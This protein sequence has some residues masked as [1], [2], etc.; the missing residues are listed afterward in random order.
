MRGVS[1]K[2]WVVLSDHIK[3]DEDLVARHGSF[4]AQL[5]VN[6]GY[7]REGDRLFD[8]K[9]K[10]LLPYRLLPNVEE[11]V[12]RIEWAVKRE[13]RIIIFGDY[14]VD[15]ITGTAILYDVLKEAGARVIPVLPTRETG[16]GLSKDLMALFS[17]Y[18]D[19][20]ITVDN[21]TSSVEEIEGFPLEV[22]VIDHHNV[23]ERVPRGC[24]IVNPRVSPETPPPMRELSSS[25]VCF[26]IAAV[27]SKRLG[28]E[29]DV[30]E[31][32]DLV[33]LGTVGD[34]MPMNYI[35]RILVHKGIKVLEGVARGVINKP[36]VRSLLKVSGIGDKVSAKDLAYSL[37]PRINAPGRIGD[38]K[39]SLKLLL[40]RDPK[41]AEVLARKVD[42][43]N[44]KRRAITEMVFRSAYRKA[45]RQEGM[46][47]LALWDRDWHVGVLGIVAGRIAEALGK[48]VAVF[49]KGETRSVGSVR[50]VE[51]VD[52]YEGLKKISHMFIKWGG[53]PQAAGITLES[54]LLED[55]SRSAEEVFRNI[56]RV[57]PPLYI[58]MRM[59]PKEFT[60]SMFRDVDS[61]EPYGE[62]NPFPTFLS[63][64]LRI[65][66]TEYRG[67]KMILDVDGIRMVC[68][69]KRLF[70][71]IDPGKSCRMV[72]SVIDR[73]FHL[74]DL[75]A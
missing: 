8:L 28:L 63:E 41:R 22:V 48:P 74:V 53:H 52:V 25:A 68:W 64:R 72:Y 27:L 3:P 69:E 32:L 12:D 71:H 31:L 26:Y 55:F 30:R 56:K 59:S 51:G 58:D 4:L 16:Y 44:A 34:V 38:P 43:L 19:L 75:E 45:V 2:A 15:G 46:S 39:V 47:F 20:L 57:P 67:G 33:A 10:H 9:L 42:L 11:C 49:S 17:R 29:R 54:S 35:N 65:R 50:S 40:E 24:V 62:R 14:D 36:G 7:E 37:A 1:G 70:P 60:E 13:K 5:I 73:E 23:P 21:G 6:R 61:L 66:R 18:G